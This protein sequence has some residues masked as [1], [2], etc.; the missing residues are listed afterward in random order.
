VLKSYKCVSCSCRTCLQFAWPIIIIIIIIIMFI[1]FI[2]THGTATA[3][4]ITRRQKYQVYASYRI[5]IRFN[6]FSHVIELL[7]GA[8][9][10]ATYSE[11]IEIDR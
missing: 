8:C 4:N 7:I 6:E 11:P 9:A 2:R 3:T 5:Y 1:M 10:V